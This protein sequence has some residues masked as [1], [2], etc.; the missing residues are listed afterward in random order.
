MPIIELS[1]CGET[2]FQKLLGYNK[3]IMYN[4]NNL[5][6]SLEKERLLSQALKE[7]LRRMLAQKN[8]CKYCKAKGKPSHELTD[9][10]SAICIGFVEVYLTLGTA[11]PDYAIKILKDHLTPSEISELIAFVSFTT[12]QQ[13]FGAIMQLEP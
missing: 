1:A 8:G 11:I 7:E 13:H 9:E 6:K 10:K 3:E 2:P 4:W 12:C 5:S